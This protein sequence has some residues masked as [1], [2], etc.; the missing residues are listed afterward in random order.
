MIDL[1]SMRTRGT[2]A[3]VSLIAALLLL[4]LAAFHAFGPLHVLGS[5]GV[6]FR[7]G[8]VVLPTSGEFADSVCGGYI[9]REGAK[10]IALLVAALVTGLAG[11]ALLH[12]PGAAD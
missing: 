4:V 5:N 10:A 7:C 11:P 12:R 2:A 6:D 1:I 9:D 3:R 8:S